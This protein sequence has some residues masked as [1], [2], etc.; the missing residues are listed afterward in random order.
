MKPAPPG[1]TRIS[2]SLYYDDAAKAIDWLC[3]A[4]GFTVRIKV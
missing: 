2:S 3:D 1:W 4:F